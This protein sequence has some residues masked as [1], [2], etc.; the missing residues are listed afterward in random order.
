MAKPVVALVQG[1]AWGLQTPPYGAAVLKGWLQSLGYTCTAFDFN[2]EFYRASGAELEGNWEPHRHQFWLDP[3]MVE[4]AMSG[5]LKP[6]VDKALERILASGATVVGFSTIYSNRNANLHLARRLKDADPR[7]ITLFGGP[8]VGRALDAR[9]VA[10][11]P[12]V[13]YVVDGEGEETLAELL[14]CLETGKDPESCAGLFFERGGRVVET[15]RR[16][17][18]ADLD[19]LPFADY[20]DFPMELYARELA[21]PVSLSRGCPNKCAFCYEVAYWERFRAR[22]GESLVAEIAH[23]KERMPFDFLWFHDS[24]L[25]GHMKSMRAFTQGVIKAKLGVRWVTQAVIRK[26]MTREVLD[27][28][29]ASGCTSMNYGLES[30]SFAVMLKMGKLLAR[31]ADVDR[32]TRDTHEAGIEVVLNFMFGFPGE[33]EADFQESLAFIERNKDWIDIVQPAPGFCDFYDGTRG[34]REPAEFG[35]EFDPAHGNAWWTAD[36]GGNTYLTRMER[37]ER[38]QAK[39]YGLGLKNAYPHEKLWMRETII[40]GYHY[41]HG[42]YEAAIPHL[43]KAV[44]EEPFSPENPRRLLDCYNKTGRREKALAFS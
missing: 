30:A 42:D 3:E 16:P 19:A 9:V 32:I 34:R 4:A 6:A 41:L 11:L 13:D 43:E 7:L 35:I 31:G 26:E 21:L 24:L 5:P 1:P 2:I 23:Q 29:A 10:A 33:T 17:L 40:G 14:R 25:N 28:A 37:F 36:G 39:A 20:S 12:E 15:A 22:S 38:F 8:Q 18:I 27:E 44:A